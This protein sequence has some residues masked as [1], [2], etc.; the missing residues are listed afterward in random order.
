M[1]FTQHTRLPDEPLRPSPVPVVPAAPGR[2][3]G[4]A[5]QTRRF[6]ETLGEWSGAL[7]QLGDDALSDVAVDLLAV[8]QRSEAVLV[9]LAR[10]AIDRGVV[11]RSTAASPTAW[12]AAASQGDPSRPSSDAGPLQPAAPVGDDGPADAADAAD[13]WR[14][15]GIE[16]AHARRICEVADAT[17]APG[18]EIVARAVR[19]GA[20]SVSVAQVCLREAPQ[21][22]A[23]LPD[24]DRA[25]VLGWYLALGSGASRSTLKALTR[26][27]I[28]RFDPDR[29]DADEA[30]LD[31]VERLRWSD[32]PNGMSRL[33]ADLT[34]AHAAQLK[35]AIDAFS[36]PRPTEDPQGSGTTAPDDR[37][38]GKRRLDALM[39]LACHGAAALDRDRPRLGALA[40]LVVTVDLAT[41]IGE[42]GYASSGCCPACGAAEP[43]TRV[44]GAG[45]TPYGDIIDAGTVRRL[46]CD[47]EI[48]PVVLGGVSE[49]LDVGRM[50]RLFTP[51]QRVALGER[52]Q[53]CSFPGC[54]RPPPWCEAHHLRPWTAGGRSTLDNGALLCERHHTVVHRDRLLGA[55]V[56]GRVVWDL[57]PG[58]MPL[59][60]HAAAADPAA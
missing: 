51:A 25:E 9:D 31:P 21:A 49:P 56:A 13:G 14:S 55:V 16:P 19:S 26:R 28:A 1:S 42:L 23:V 40:R 30:R 7:H 41:L 39:L 43:A 57:T 11:Q 15:P 54:D 12:L 5:D 50:Q 27:I 3:A 45:S 18:N 2:A 59:S 32:L 52:D 60:Q 58:R 47:A 44:P 36:A 37:T 4:L 20:A 17:R 34:S 6:V 22:L 53:G 38:P 46:A 48:V 33:E 29:L 10:E 24:A 8:L 35:Q